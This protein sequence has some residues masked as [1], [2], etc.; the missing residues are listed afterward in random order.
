MFLKRVRTRGAAH[1]P[2]LTSM[3][4]TGLPGAGP[5]GVFGLLG[6]GPAGVSGLPGGGPA[7]VGGL[8]IGDCD[9][10]SGECVIW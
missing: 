6:A 10:G 1:G 9:S 2:M 4:W 3:T 8:L 7:G 5:V